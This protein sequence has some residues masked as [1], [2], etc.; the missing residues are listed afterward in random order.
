MTH[1]DK[2]FD[3][4]EDVRRVAEEVANRLIGRGIPMA[5]DEAPDDLVRLLDAV[6]HFEIAVESRGG[7]LMVDEPPNPAR[8]QPDDP[9]FVLP[10]RAHD[11]TVGRYI[12]RV[13]RA[14]QAVLLQHRR[15]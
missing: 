7:D 3:R 14:T 13:R 10:R 5:G 8:P 11:E 15:E 1:P 4:T 2:R 9:H 6:E 12:D